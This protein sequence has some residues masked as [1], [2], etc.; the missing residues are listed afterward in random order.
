MMCR[1]IVPMTLMLSG[2]Y[3]VVPYD[4]YEPDMADVLLRLDALEAENET[5][6]GLLATAQADLDALIEH[7]RALA[8]EVVGIDPVSDDLTAFLAELETSRIDALEEVSGV[9]CPG[10]CVG[11]DDLAGFATET[12]VQGQ[13]YATLGEVV[14]GDAAL[15]E[16]I[17]ALEDLI[18]VIEADYVTSSMLEGL[19]TGPRVIDTD[20]T[21][22]V[23]TD[24]ADIQDA[25]DSLD[26]A[27]IMGD[28]VVTIEVESGHCG[29]A[30]TEPIRV[31]HRDGAHIEVV[32]N[33]LAPDACVLSFVGT[34]A[35]LELESGT[36]L[37][38]FT[39]FTLMGQTSAAEA[40]G[41]ILERG[42]ALRD[43]GS[44]V[45]T[46]W[47]GHGATIIAAD[48]DLSG[49]TTRDNGG[50]G[51]AATWASSVAASGLTSTGNGGTGASF[52]DGSIAVLDGAEVTGNARDG[53]LFV[54]GSGGS[55]V[56][57]MLSD[58][59]S[60]GISLD[61]VAWL[62]ASESVANNNGDIGAHI[63]GASM[64]DFFAGEAVGNGF[65]GLSADHLGVIRGDEA[66]V[67]GSGSHGVMVQHGATAVVEGSTSSGNTG[68]GYHVRFGGSLDAYA[69]TAN[70][71]GVFG[72]RAASGAFVRGAESVADGN[73]DSGFY[74]DVGSTANLDGA[75]AS[76]NEGEA[77]FVF[78][79]G[80]GGSAAR[81]QA[82][83]N[84]I[85][86]V[87]AHGAA[88]RMEDA[89]AADNLTEGVVVNSGG[90]ITA[91]R[92]VA[93]D[94]GG[95]GLY[96]TRSGFAD[97]IHGQVTGNGGNGVF[98]GSG[99]DVYAEDSLSSG[100]GLVGYIADSGGNIYAPYAES[101]DN[102]LH[103]L[104]AHGGSH[105]DF[106]VG[107]VSGNGGDSA[108]VAVGSLIRLDSAVMSGNP[109]VGP[110]SQDENFLSGLYGIP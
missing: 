17:E 83:R 60:H 70:D 61:A 19:S 3:D 31:G 64:L 73:G 57:S 22:L 109:A 48:A 93:R 59:G 4:I 45:L 74:I 8:A 50:D 85:G 36:E 101:D 12:W 18:F 65:Y 34:S 104:S 10:G 84:P 30:Y 1:L 40:S 77:G 44:L 20:L 110:T 78:I 79:S 53:L 63:G 54:N 43:G 97:V 103:G 21:I 13:G 56:G 107:D 25:L 89:V 26:D 81:A 82:L 80:A 47:S 68:D 42:S 58:N 28:A 35:G 32:G 72:M 106:R 39:G 2:C 98:A 94:N 16:E 100:N 86:F 91:A 99:A 41:L 29:T 105:I 76:D 51:L 108:Y 49:L 87:V 102:G 88:V 23:P 55:A 15:A 90:A 71:N 95:V 11:V 27:L 9:S 96:T 38:A 5:L 67:S 37:G 46:G 6:S 7:E 24:A 69:S 33:T 75:V 66:S 62:D 92:L 14:A 52:R